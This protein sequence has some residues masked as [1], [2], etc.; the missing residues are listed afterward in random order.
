LAILAVLIVFS[1]IWVKFI[2]KEPMFKPATIDEVEEYD[3]T[4]PEAIDG[5][6]S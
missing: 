2:K 4:S 5:V 3:T 1:V 6:A